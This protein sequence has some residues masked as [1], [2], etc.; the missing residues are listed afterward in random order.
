MFEGQA[1]H[2]AGFDALMT[3]HVFVSAFKS[4]HYEPKQLKTESF[5]KN[6]AFYCNKVRLGN[7]RLP[8]KF[9]GDN[10]IF[11]S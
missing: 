8:F 5:K 6:A 4:L 1:A 11:E 10:E 3:A 7:L 2:E 9:G